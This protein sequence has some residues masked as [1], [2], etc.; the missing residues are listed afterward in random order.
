[1]YLRRNCCAVIKKTK[2]VCEFVNNYCNQKQRLL[3]KVNFVV[4]VDNTAKNVRLCISLASY[5]TPRL[6][7]Y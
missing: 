1:M 7:F 2:K 4:F 6:Q 5:Y 3:L